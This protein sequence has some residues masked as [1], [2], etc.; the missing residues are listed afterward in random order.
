MSTVPVNASVARVHDES[1]VVALRCHVAG[2]APVDGLC[3]GD[4]RASGKHDR[5]EQRGAGTHAPRETAGCRS[6]QG[7]IRGD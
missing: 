1:Q 7:G 5:G 4:V 3:G 2:Q 6:N